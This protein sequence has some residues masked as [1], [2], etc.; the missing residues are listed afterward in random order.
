MEPR[1][2]GRP[3]LILVENYAL[4]TVGALPPDAEGGVRDVVTRVYGGGDDWRETLRGAL[5]WPDTIDQE[6]LDNWRRYREAARA[7]KAQANPAEFAQRF[8]DAVWDAAQQAQS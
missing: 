5:R 7:Q 6:I 8:A 4:A 1:Y 3:L 2:T